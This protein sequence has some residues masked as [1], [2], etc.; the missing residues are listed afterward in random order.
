[1]LAIPAGHQARRRIETD[2]GRGAVSR[3]QIGLHLP[4]LGAAG[5]QAPDLQRALGNGSRGQG[6][7]L[8]GNASAASGP[9]R[10]RGQRD[11]PPRRG[12]GRWLVVQDQRVP[13]RCVLRKRQTGQRPHGRFIGQAAATPRNRRRQRSCARGDG[14]HHRQGDGDGGQRAGRGGGGRLIIKHQGIGR[15]LIGVEGHTGH[16]AC[17]WLHLQT[18][19][20]AALRRTIGRWRA[21]GGNDARLRQRHG[22]HLLRGD[23]VQ[24]QAAQDRRGVRDACQQT[25]AQVVQRSRLAAHDA[26]HGGCRQ[27]QPHTTAQGQAA[28]RVLEL[29]FGDRLPGLAVA[30]LPGHAQGV[31]TRG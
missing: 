7:G 5:G 17:V 3:I 4:G 13:S 9:G 6:N 15:Q 27:S 26:C 28:G 2:P 30:V 16:S 18:A 11:Q 19:Q 21:A 1:M 22:P 10:R 14:A 23:G 29:M 31:V 12:R 25:A 24:P 8:P 20:R